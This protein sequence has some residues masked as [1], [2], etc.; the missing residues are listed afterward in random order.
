[1][2]LDK[3]LKVARLAKR[4]TEAKEALDAGRIFDVRGR[5]LKPGYDVKA[6]DVL[7]IHYARK[8]LTVRVESVPLRVTPGVKPVE[9]YTILNDRKETDTWV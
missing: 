6:G 8:I 4:R 1:L 3:F 7:E 9:L 2:R 5:P